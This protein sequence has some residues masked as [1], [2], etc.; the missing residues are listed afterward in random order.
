MT[1]VT[2]GG[3]DAR[4]YGE[5]NLGIPRVLMCV[6][7]YTAIRVVLGLR[8]LMCVAHGLAWLIYASIHGSILSLWYTLP[9][10][11]CGEMLERNTF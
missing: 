4:T 10:T 6:H 11:N 2:E 1:M 3:Q 5:Q 8:S 9:R 7:A